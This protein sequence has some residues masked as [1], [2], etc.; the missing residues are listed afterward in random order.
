[1]CRKDGLSYN[2]QLDA[3]IRAEAFSFHLLHQVWGGRSFFKSF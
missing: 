3:Q 2:L 1:M